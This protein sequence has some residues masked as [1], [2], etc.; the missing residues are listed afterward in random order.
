MPSVVSA[1]AVLSQTLTPPSSS[2][3][4]FIIL[5]CT[6]RLSVLAGAAIF[7]SLASFVGEFWNEKDELA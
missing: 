7:A 2:L 1:F 3:A 5:L 4:Y 6:G